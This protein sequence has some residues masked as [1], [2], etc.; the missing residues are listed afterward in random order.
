MTIRNWMAIALLVL[1][2]ACGKNGKVGQLQLSTGH[3]YGG[4]KVKEGELSAVAYIQMEGTKLC[5][6]VLV[7]SQLILTAGHCLRG[8]EKS[9]LQ[10]GFGLQVTPFEDKKNK[11]EVEELATAPGFLSRH[12]TQLTASLADFD[13]GYLK[14]KNT[15]NEIV[16]ISIVEGGV[17]HPHYLKL[18]SSADAKVTHV[19]FG[20]RINL[21]KEAMDPTKI[22]Q[23]LKIESK[24]KKVSPFGIYIESGADK[25]ISKGDSGG[26]VILNTKA[27]PKVLAIV[28][29]IH[30]NKGNKSIPIFPYVCWIEKET[31][32]DISP[33]GTCDHYSDHSIKQLESTLYDGKEKNTE[34]LLMTAFGLAV[35]HTKLDLV[36]SKVIDIGLKAKEKK[37]VQFAF[38]I[39]RYLNI[40]RD[41]FFSVKDQFLDLNN[42]SINSMIVERLAHWNQFDEMEYG[43][44]N[45]ILNIKGKEKSAAMA[46]TLMAQKY[47]GRPGKRTEVVTKVINYGLAANPDS[48]AQALATL[49]ATSA[50]PE[51]S[52]EEAKVYLNIIERIETSSN[53]LVRSDAAIHRNRL[54]AS[55]ARAEVKAE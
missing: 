3:I 25:G 29:N 36:I 1:L 42:D 8:V 17:I 33:N 21:F 9:E 7:H 38:E 55:I 19:G 28:G 53:R 48:F 52:M 30:G 15:V 47:A 26:P 39:L 12:F 34:S 11:Y 43:I 10:V 49:D 16:P 2:G 45:R 37:Y 41:T 23:K 5:T 18:I 35:R 13:I 24:V 31:K 54:L 51:I 4:E 50:C 46:L 40:D 27:G 14:L 32:L 20:L 22:G 44:L 6:G